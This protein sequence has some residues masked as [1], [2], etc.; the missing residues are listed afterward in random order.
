MWQLESAA[1][2][3]PRDS[4]AR[5]PAQEPRKK[6]RPRLPS[7]LLAS[8][9]PRLLLASLCAAAPLASPFR[10][11]PSSTFRVASQPWASWRSSSEN[12]P[13]LGRVFSDCRS[14]P[15]SSCSSPSWSR[16]TRPYFSP[17]LL[18][19]SNPSFSNT[20]ACLHLNGR[21]VYFSV[22]P[23]RRCVPS[24]IETLCVVSNTD[25]Y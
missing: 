6:Q 7:L 23:A 20:F 1:A 5:A 4:R 22:Q 25:S 2:V 10:K 8:S 19:N 16:G 9:F 3:V 15:S 11:P 12:A 13:C 17:P 18:V 24:E 21:I 14:A